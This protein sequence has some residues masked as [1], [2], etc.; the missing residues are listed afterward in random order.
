VLSRNAVASHP[1]AAVTARA[2]QVA[3]APAATTH[4]TDLEITA[5]P[6]ALCASRRI[7]CA[8]VNMPSS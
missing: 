5:P 7:D 4:P 8:I 3:P 1:P 2:L 6:A